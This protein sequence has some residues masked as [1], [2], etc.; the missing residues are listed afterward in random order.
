MTL[1]LTSAALA[2]LVLSWSLAAREAPPGRDEVQPVRPKITGVAHIALYAKD[3]EAARAFYR[4]FLGFAEPYSLQ[5]P[6]GSPG[7]TF[8]K[9]NER[10]YI[11]LF[12]ERAS[13]TDR[14]NHI[15]IETDDAEGMRQY[16]AAKGVKVPAKVGKGRIGNSNFNIVDPEGHTVEIVQ[17]EPEG[18]T[19][20][21]Q[22][23]HLPPARVA[24]RIMHVGIIVT[25]YDAVM[26][27]YTEV[28]GFTETWRG[29]R[30]PKVLSWVNLK[31]PDG[32]DYIEL[33][34]HGTAPAPTARGSAHHLA[35]EVPDIERGVAT[36]EARKTAAGYTR[37]IEIRTGVNR[38]RQSNFFD[39]DG[40]RTELMEPR[41]IDGVPAPPSLAPP[42][43]RAEPV[44]R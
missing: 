9:V 30:D 19:V 11:E 44:V 10:Q 37:P 24:S 41:T 36:L 25:A 38:K 16:L 15:A 1:R 28:L 14:L 43:K 32:D 27:F 20:R 12:P 39:P 8:F 21:E 34:L 2:C 23:R 29:G 5:N 7:M 17:Y 35:L 33:M 22:G 6:D 3:F 42:P 40:T 4:D 18:W 31:V 13:G 26:R